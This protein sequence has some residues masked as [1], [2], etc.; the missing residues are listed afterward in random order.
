MAFRTRLYEAIRL[1]SAQLAALPEQEDVQVQV[2]PLLV[3][4]ASPDCKFIA[5]TWKLRDQEVVARARDDQIRDD[6]QV[7]LRLQAA[8]DLEEDPEVIVID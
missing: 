4:A 7:A 3:H 5:C 1:A 8:M 6:H 2:A